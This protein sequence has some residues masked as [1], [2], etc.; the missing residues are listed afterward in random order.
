MRVCRMLQSVPRR[1]VVRRRK[2]R[3]LAH[4]KLY[5]WMDY[6]SL[7]SQRRKYLT[8]YVVE[9][10]AFLQTGLQEEYPSSQFPDGP[11]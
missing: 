1:S 9:I 11:S 8:T 10:M 5:Q 7:Y 2:E 3:I 6:P 4:R